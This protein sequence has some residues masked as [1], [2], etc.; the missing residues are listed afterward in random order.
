MTRP[1][2]RAGTLGA[3]PRE[4]TVT[5]VDL[6]GHFVSMISNAVWLRLPERCADLRLSG[7]FRAP[8]RGYRNITGEAPY[9]RHEM[10]DG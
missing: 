2:W 6:A 5:R 1:A 4:L 9:R 10:G 7:S 3:K 8:R